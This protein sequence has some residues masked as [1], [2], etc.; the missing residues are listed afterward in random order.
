MIPVFLPT[1]RVC[2]AFAVALNSAQYLEISLRAIIHT[3]DFH[4][5]IEELPPIEEQPPR[6]KDANDFI[7]KATL[8]S[9]I[10]A[11][12]RSGML[13]S[14]T[15]AGKSWKRILKVA[16]EYRNQLAHRYLAE[17][18]FDKLDEA[19]EDRIVT[20]LEQMESKSSLALFL[21][22]SVQSRLE[23][24]SDQKNDRMNAL[25][26]LPA[27]CD[28]PSRKFVPKQRRQKKGGKT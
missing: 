8:G 15:A 25:L 1:N 17:Q 13:K 22:D 18:D 24:L 11:L 28:S 14:T 6:F 21:A 16:C 4:G 26:E 27:D 9:L 5:W 3:L 10:A 7:D 20:E 12:D 23:L 2:Y 19:M